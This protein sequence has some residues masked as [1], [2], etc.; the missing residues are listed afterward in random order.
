[1]LSA[2]VM[3]VQTPAEKRYVRRSVLLFVVFLVVWCPWVGWP[4]HMTAPRWEK[5]VADVTPGIVFAFFLWEFRRYLRSLDELARKLQYES[6]AW[7]YLIG[8]VVWAASWVQW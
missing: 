7:T 8:L 1:M 6:M 2:G 4:G 3:G 5:I